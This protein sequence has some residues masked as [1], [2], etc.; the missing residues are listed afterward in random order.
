MQEE[1]K[2]TYE[3]DDDYQDDEEEF[4]QAEAESEQTVK[5]KGR[6]EI[7]AVMES[8]KALLTSGTSKETLVGQ[9]YSVKKIGENG[10]TQKVDLTKG[11]H[12]GSSNAIPNKFS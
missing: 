1:Q 3:S 7:N 11:M 12:Y 8:Q 10:S 2:E 5:V 9:K 6:Q 4:D